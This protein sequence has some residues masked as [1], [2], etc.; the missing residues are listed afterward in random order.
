MENKEKE[1]KKE[2]FR[3][4][5]LT[6]A[7]IY[8]MGF[9]NAYALGTGHW[10]LG[11]M[12]TP[13]TG[14][15]IWIGKNLA[16]GNW[17]YLL[18]NLALFLGFIGGVIFSHLAQNIFAYK[19]KQYIFNWSIFIF[20]IIIFPITMH[21]K[22][23]QVAFL[24]IGFS[25][26]VGLGFFRKLY[27]LDINNA[28]ATGN[29]RFLGMWFAEAFIK[30]SR[31]EKKEVFTFQLFLICVSA[32]AFGAFCYVMA[33]K[34][35]GTEIVKF[36]T[37]SRYTT[38]VATFYISEIVLIIICVTPYFF[39]PRDPDFVK[40]KGQYGGGIDATSQRAYGGGI[41]KK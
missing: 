16:E 11:S 17:P 20:P 26:G 8:I 22:T 5:F 10:L 36:Y 6:V 13:Q 37:S 23:P 41:D 38:D 25:S 35:G 40:P 14:N 33:A 12:V 3:Y 4:A 19:L 39:I 30:K 32:F 27:H 31:T 15:I 9:I 24:I 29:V 7:S 18:S 1:Q 2:I 34:L 21:F 28:M